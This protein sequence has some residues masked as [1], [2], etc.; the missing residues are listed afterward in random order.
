MQSVQTKG[1]SG[2]NTKNAAAY[3]LSKRSTSATGMKS[4]H[5]PESSQLQR[6]K[7]RA[8]TL[9]RGGRNVHT[10]KGGRATRKKGKFQAAKRGGG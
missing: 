2:K 4:E 6:S 3:V 8:R 5:G 9:L 1:N 7:T 10:P